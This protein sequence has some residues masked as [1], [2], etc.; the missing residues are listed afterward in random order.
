M[1]ETTSAKADLMAALVR[2]FEAG[3]DIGAQTD[4]APRHLQQL[5]RA[6]NA[7]DDESARAFWRSKVWT[8]NER[9]AVVRAAEAWVRFAEVIGR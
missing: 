6:L 8:D 3:Y 1:P 4:E 7:G 2:G 9:R 5:R